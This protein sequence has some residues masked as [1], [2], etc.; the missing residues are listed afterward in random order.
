MALIMVDNFRNSY[1]FI[2]LPKYM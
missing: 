1:A 2:T